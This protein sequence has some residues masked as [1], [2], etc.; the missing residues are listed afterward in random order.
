[1]KSLH[2]TNQFHQ[3]SGGISTF[4]RSLFTVAGE[5]GHRL[6][7]VASGEQDQTE[8]IN[9]YVTIHYLAAP[10]APF[11]DRRY[12]VIWPGSYL[13]PFG[14][15]GR[16]L[17]QL[18]CAEQP[19]LIE[20]GEKYTLCWLAGM[21]RKGMIPGT[22]RPVLIGTSHERMDDNVRVFLTPRAVG[23][24][25]S[26]RYLGHLYIPLFDH[27]LANSR[28]TAA[29]LEQA[30]VDRHQRPV[31]VIPMGADIER[32]QQIQPSVEWRNE[33]VSRIGG[34]VSTRLLL[35]V[36]RLSPEKNVG[37]LV[38]LMEKL[39]RSADTDYRLLIA[40]SGP[41]EEWLRR[42]AR[43]RAP[44]LIHLLGQIRQGVDKS[45]LAQLYVNCDAFIHPN[46][47]EP[48]GIAPLEAMAAGLPLIAPD[49]G[50][51]L[52]YAN[53]NNAWLSAPNGETY[54]RAVLAIFD[55]PAERLERVRQARLTA[56]SYHWGKI[57]R[58]HLQRYREIRE[59]FALKHT[60]PGQVRSGTLPQS[61][62]EM[63]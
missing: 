44:G 51:V 45:D 60:V 25:M 27:H 16:R 36:G 54:A 38:D 55:H 46:P 22:G 48:F 18:L 12:R 49:R 35:Y 33:L 30:M 52:T 19:D 42:E 13:N 24:G 15:S 37:L 10:A 9:D 21:I 14:A 8:Q 1:L 39:R 11:F 28:Y 50:G 23:R 7:L 32:Y 34:G 41:L 5:T 17:R 2:L 56:E 59:S 40:G 47:R 58:L 61:R 29:E 62:G 26:Q 4:Y 43:Q 20:I 57:A 31:E 63:S 53:G 6:V 3:T